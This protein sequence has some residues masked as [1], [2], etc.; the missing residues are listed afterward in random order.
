MERRFERHTE[1]VT[2][3]AVDSINPEQPRV[4]SIDESRNAI[5]WDLDSG[6]EIA[7]YRS[8]DEITVATWMKNGNLVFGRLFNSLTVFTVALAS[9]RH[10][11]LDEGRSNSKN[12]LVQKEIW[13]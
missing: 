1:K 4:V 11:V 13:S 5:V 8:E 7:T 2:I 3:L 9:Y 10:P 12:S 6:D